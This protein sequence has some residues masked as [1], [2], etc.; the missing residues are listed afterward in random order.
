[1]G[2]GLQL[3]R[4]AESR[5]TR[6]I[7]SG[8]LSR[9]GRRSV[10]GR[11]FPL[12]LSASA[13]CPKPTSALRDFGYFAVNHKKTEQIFGLISC[14][15]NREEI[16]IITLPVNTGENAPPGSLLH[17]LSAV[18]QLPP[19]HVGSHDPLHLSLGARLPSPSRPERAGQL[20]FRIR[21]VQPDLGEGRGRE[22]EQLG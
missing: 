4:T 11:A 8:C 18:Q 15:A 20:E 22:R 13:C 9:R 1:M 14:R 6:R 21:Q 16:R 3:D 17:K 5:E 19:R 12:A 2:P 10:L 7:L